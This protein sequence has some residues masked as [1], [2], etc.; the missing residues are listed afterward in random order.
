MRK[1]QT[2]QQQQQGVS[3]FDE[4]DKPK[5]NPRG[6][7]LGCYC[8]GICNRYHVKVKW[9]QNRYSLGLKM[10]SYC[11]V[12]LDIVSTRCPCCHY[13]LRSKARSKPKKEKKTT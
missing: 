5:R 4:F 10:C 2:L 11:N 3:V 6:T 12:W 7:R 9:G 8:K 1:D 13:M